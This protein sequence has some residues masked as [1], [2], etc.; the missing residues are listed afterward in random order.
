MSRDQ[1]LPVTQSQVDTDREDADREFTGPSA[2]DPRLFQVKAMMKQQDYQRPVMERSAQ[3]V[4]TCDSAIQ[5]VWYW[6]PN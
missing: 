1:P 3:R 4:Y 6:T 2:S 5:S